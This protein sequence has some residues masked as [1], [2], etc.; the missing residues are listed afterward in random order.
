MKLFEI[1]QSFLQL[2]LEIDDNGGELT[3]ELEER[4]NITKDEFEKKFIN[5]YNLI[6]ML[7]SDISF[8]KDKKKHLDSANKR[9]QSII[10]SLKNKMSN[11]LELFGTVTKTGSITYIFPDLKVSIFKKDYLLYDMDEIEKNNVNKL[12][13]IFETDALDYRYESLEFGIISNGK[14]ETKLI[15]DLLDKM[16][17]NS[18]NIKYTM[19]IIHDKS[20]IQSLIESNEVIKGYYIGKKDYQFRY[21]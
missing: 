17:I 16:H 3:P 5:Y 21:S 7:E 11:A 8:I 6:K 12:A 19:K 10:D 2:I 13:T 15:L 20:M 1:E 14:E 4:L 18:S 9:K